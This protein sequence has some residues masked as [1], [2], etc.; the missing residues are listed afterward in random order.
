MVVITGGTGFIGRFLTQKLL[1]EGYKVCWLVR[2]KAKISSQVI[3]QYWNPSRGILDRKALTEATHIV[4]LAGAPIASVPWTSARRKVLWESR[5]HSTRLIVDTIRMLPSRPKVLVSASAIGFYP[6]GNQEI[7]EDTSRGQGFLS[8]LTEAWEKEALE[9]EKLGVRVVCLRIG[10]VLGKSGGALAPL[11]RAV[12]IGVAPIL[13]AGR[14]YVSWIHQKDLSHLLLTTLRQ[15]KWNGIYNATAP[16]PVQQSEFM[17]TLASASDKK[18]LFLPTPSFL[19]R[20]V[21]GQRS[22]L[23]LD[24]QQILPNRTLKTGFSFTFPTLSHAL[25]DLLS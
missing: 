23:I 20:T 13:G 25:Q 6:C 2:R 10:L 18:A 16:Q 15:E 11:L 22:Q 7:T 5:I 14:Q 9:A 12:R 8:E 24:S 3:C 19:L 4:N 1:E 21:L 17:H